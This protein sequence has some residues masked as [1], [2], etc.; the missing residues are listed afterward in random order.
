[1]EFRPRR[2]TRGSSANGCVGGRGSDSVDRSLGE[3]EREACGR[4]RDDRAD[5][6]HGSKAER[7]T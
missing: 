6:R 4:A 3:T 7:D 5:L 2:V 1:M